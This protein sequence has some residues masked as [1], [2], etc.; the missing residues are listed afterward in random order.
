LFNIFFSELKE[1]ALKNGEDI[2]LEEEDARELFKMMQEE[3]SDAL[4]DDGMDDLFDDS[5]GA[6][7]T[8]VPTIENIESLDSIDPLSLFGESDSDSNLQSRA[9]FHDDE[10]R[11][12][13]GIIEQIK[14]DMNVDDLGLDGDEYEGETVSRDTD[15][16]SSLEDVNILSNSAPEIQLMDDISTASS[17]NQ[18][19]SQQSLEHSDEVVL[20]EFD[21][22]EL[23]KI[24]DLQNAL[25]GMPLNRIKKILKA[26]NSTLGDPSLITLV[27]ILR[28]TIPD[29]ISSGW[30]KRINT[31]NADFV[32]QK[33]SEDG[34][35][36]TPLLNTMLQV[37]TSGASLD[38]ALT[39]Y[40]EEYR[41]HKKVR[42]TI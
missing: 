31:R 28:E 22:D 35:I 41:K 25:P 27:P 16:L 38:E 20:S 32:L 12:I 18:P 9:P 13:E 2:D 29:Y 42:D 1:E 37:K 34:L 33:A 11:D 15:R 14:K 7:E 19:I 4:G 24:K 6:R 30:L 8:S 21:S 3:F 17:M 39:F 5:M 23:E 36:D 40:D 10:T 26:F